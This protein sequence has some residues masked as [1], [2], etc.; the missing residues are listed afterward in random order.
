MFLP[1]SHDERIKDV[2]FEKPDT[3]LVHCVIIDEDPYMFTICIEYS[4]SPFDLIEFLRS[5]ENS[6]YERLMKEIEQAVDKKKKVNKE[7]LPLNA[8][9]MASKIRQT[10]ISLDIVTATNKSIADQ[11]KA[12]ELIRELASQGGSIVSALPHAPMS[13]TQRV[14]STRSRVVVPSTLKQ[15]KLGEVPLQS[16]RMRV[17]RPAEGSTT[18]VFTKILLDLEPGEKTDYNKT[19]IMYEKFWLEYQ[20]CFVFKVDKKFSININQLYRAPKD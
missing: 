18:S 1:I 13:R 4:K 11:M 19:K 2:F 10:V 17:S 5:L 8:R 20:D 3:M 15:Q 12:I 14:A 16:K 7:G 6:A 9:S